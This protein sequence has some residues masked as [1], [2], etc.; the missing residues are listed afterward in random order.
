MRQ[1]RTGAGGKSSPDSLD[2]RFSG[3]FSSKE[4]SFRTVREREEALAL[5]RRIVTKLDIEADVISLETLTGGRSI[6][7]VF[8]LTLDKTKAAP[9]V[10]HG[11]PI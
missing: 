2:I 8:R 11:S 3:P 7:H 5:V 4:P 9:V 10:I 1:A 6:S